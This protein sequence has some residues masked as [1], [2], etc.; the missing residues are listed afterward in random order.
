M[1]Y[2]SIKISGGYTVSR[3][4]PRQRFEWP[5]PQATDTDGDGPAR[6]PHLKQLEGVR[7]YMERTL[8]ERMSKG[9]ALMAQLMAEM[10]GAP[11]VSDSP[12]PG[13][14]AVPAS[15]LWDRYILQL[16]RASVAL[17]KVEATIAAY[18]QCP[19]HELAGPDHD[20][21]TCRDVAAD[22]RYHI[23]R[24]ASRA[25]GPE[26]R[27]ELRRIHQREGHQVLADLL[28]HEATQ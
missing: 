17:G 21:D 5:G 6:I 25:P 19:D 4:F 23:Y 22:G 26:R 2:Y 9:S 28:F 12:Y 10:G 18:S 14:R 13:A 15:K 1:K 27:R 3:P 8:G 24:S 11:A 20:C 7:A 16:G